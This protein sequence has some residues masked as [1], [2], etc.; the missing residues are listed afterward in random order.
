MFGLT[1]AGGRALVPDETVESWTREADH[2]MEAD[3]APEGDSGHG[4]SHAALGAD[5]VSGLSVERDG[6]RLGPMLAPGR[7]GEEGRLSFRIHGPDGRPQTRYRTNHERKLHLIAVRVDGE[8]FQH[9]HPRMD[10]SGTWSLPVTWPLAGTYRVYADFV[11]PG[12]DQPVTLARNVE[13]AGQF[14]PSSKPLS[15]HDRTG[16][17]EVTLT[18]DLVAGRATDLDVRITR[19]G[20]P[21]THLQPYLG[22]FGHLVAL[23]EGDLA[24]LHVHAEEDHGEEPG[25][26]GPD[27][28]GHP[29][30]TGVAGPEIGFVA[31]AP[32]AGRYLLYLDFRVDG[33]VRTAEFVLEAK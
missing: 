12:E 11:P 14:T 27:V 1:F 20:Q 29:H 13:V 8:G 4:D 6:Y 10:R 21:E 33:K 18:G 9:L 22:A 28:G 19:N 17:F 16:D 15:R 7:S 25:Q 30:A 5:D 26:H 32:T 31:E 2:E 24:Y 3:H 23:R